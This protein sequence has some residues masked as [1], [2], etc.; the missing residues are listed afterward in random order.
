MSE[1]SPRPEVGS[2]RPSG[3]AVWLHAVRSPV[4]IAALARRAEERGARALLLADE[5]TDRDLYVTLTAVALA[6]RSLELVPAITNPHSRHPVATAA[7]LASLAEI[8][9]GRVTAGLGVGGQLVLGPMGLR[10]RRPYTALV[11]T[12]EV[13]ERLLAGEQVSHTGEF[14]VDHARLPWAPGRLPLAIA[15]R[16][17]RVEALAARR[18]DRVIL[19]GKPRAELPGLVEALRSREDGGPLVLWNP[20][21][22][23]TVEHRAEVRS[24]LAFM[25][26]DM[27]ARWREDLGVGEDVVARLR[28]AVRTRGPHA[29]A[30]LVPEAIVSAFSVSG[31]RAHVVAR[32]TATVAQ[33]RP[34]VVTLSPPA[35]TLEAVDEL[36][37]VAAAVGLGARQDA[38]A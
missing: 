34:D 8:A 26:G 4:E 27:P 17:P 37:D 12:V 20:A 24:H 11:E 10:P 31:D 30:P 28:E 23:W 29:A 7:A 1:R 38:V 13:V 22:A 32:L 33:V 5:G 2:T 14:T 19:A 6:T 35:Y 3:W 25:T 9:P 18:A 21:A 16:G 36:A 15:G